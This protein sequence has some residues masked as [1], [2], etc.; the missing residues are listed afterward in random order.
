MFWHSM[1]G[2][3]VYVGG[4]RKWH[5]RRAFTVITATSAAVTAIAITVSITMMAAAAVIIATTTIS[6]FSPPHHLVY[7]GLKQPMFFSSRLS[8]MTSQ[9]NTKDELHCSWNWEIE[10][11]GGLT[12]KEQL[13]SNKI[14]NP[15]FSFNLISIVCIH[16]ITFQKFQ[17]FPLGYIFRR[18]QLLCVLSTD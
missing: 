1:K 16:G 14:R 13:V 2:S 4:L 6:S 11:V 18:A 15:Q 9:C 3:Q 17:C 5:L 7:S 8:C 12:M 10:M